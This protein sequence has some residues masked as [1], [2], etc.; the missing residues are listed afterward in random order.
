MTQDLIFDQSSLDFAAIL[1]PVCT[2]SD[3][4]AV[5]SSAV[6]VATLETHPVT[7]W[8]KCAVPVVTVCF[9]SVAFCAI[10]DPKEV[11]HWATVDQNS[12]VFVATLETHPVTH[13]TK[14]AVPVVTVC[15]ASTVFC[16]TA[17][18]RDVAHWA[19]FDHS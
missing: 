11:A 3:L 7:H 15:F 1:A 2:T 14:C 10:V 9:A 13:W 18:P 4:I 16:A 12:A 8:A 17:D 19:M 5:P 6:F